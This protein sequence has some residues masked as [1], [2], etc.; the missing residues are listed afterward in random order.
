MGIVAIDVETTGIDPEF[1]GVQLNWFDYWKTEIAIVTVLIFATIGI[2][3][4]YI[5]ILFR[6]D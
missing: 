4:L 6:F 3:P 1:E 5:H 2:I